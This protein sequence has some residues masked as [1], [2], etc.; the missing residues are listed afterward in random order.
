MAFSPQNR[1]EE[2]LVQ[3]T[4][5]PAH[6]PEFFREL[7]EATVYVLGH[8]EEETLTEHSLRAGSGLQLQHWEKPDGSSAIVFFSSLAAL[9]QAVSEEQAF[10]AL[11]TRTLF[12]TTRGATLFLNPKLPYGKE[13]LPQEIEHL[14]AGESGNSLAQQQILDGDVALKISVPDALPAQMTH[15]LTE[16]FKKHGYVK[17][18]FMAHIQEPDETEPHWLIGLDAQGDALDALIQEA[19]AVATD[20]QPDDKPVDLCVVSENEPGISHFLIRH[21]TPFYERKWGS[22]LRDFKKTS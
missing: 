17:R 1:L 7:L 4:S 2:V 14:L 8:S 13:F 15:S 12:E 3:A 16:L 6:R 21:T 18:A 22:F 11:P 20:T 5:E 9:Q 19:G 10:L